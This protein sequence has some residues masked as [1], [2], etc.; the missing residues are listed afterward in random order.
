MDFLLKFSSILERRIYEV[1]N[2]SSKQATTFSIGCYLFTDP[3]NLMELSE[4][5]RYPK[6]RLISTQLLQEYE[7][8][9][10][11]ALWLLVEWTR[12]RADVSWSYKFGEVKHSAGFP[13]GQALQASVSLTTA[14]RYEVLTA[15]SP[16]QSCLPQTRDS[17]S[18][19]S[20]ESHGARKTE[21]QE[22]HL[23]YAE[24]HVQGHLSTSKLHFSLLLP[25]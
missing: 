22:T 24:A 19:T 3:N 6:A 25:F 10:L 5:Q 1:G 20:T 11:E 8:L 15:S 17:A 9:C 14:V 23:N 4:A 2:N 7:K 21:L 16:F 18:T 13:Q 12:P